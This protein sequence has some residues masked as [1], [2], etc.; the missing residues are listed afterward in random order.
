MRS[1]G[2]DPLRC[3]ASC[4]EKKKIGDV[5]EMDVDQWVYLSSFNKFANFNPK[6]ITHPTAFRKSLDKYQRDPGFGSMNRGRT[7]VVWGA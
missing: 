1:C 5:R 7:G 4:I 2:R 6:S 3:W